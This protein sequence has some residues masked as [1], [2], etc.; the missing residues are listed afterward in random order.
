MRRTI[1]LLVSSTERLTAEVRRSQ[2]AVKMTLQTTSV[3]R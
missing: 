1:V 3:V 2:E